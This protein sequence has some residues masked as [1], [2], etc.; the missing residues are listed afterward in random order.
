MMRPRDELKRLLFETRVQEEVEKRVSQIVLE[1][2]HQFQLKLM[3][4]EQRLATLTRTDQPFSHEEFQVLKIALY[5][6]SVASDET[7]RKAWDLVWGRRAVL[8]RP[9]VKL[10]GNRARTLPETREELEAW[11]RKVDAQRAA[12][13]KAK[14]DAKKNG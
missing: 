3:E 8:A 4:Q 1:L 9:Q 6:L 11:K 2:Q 14:R 13:R 12:E 5:P 10:V 7:K